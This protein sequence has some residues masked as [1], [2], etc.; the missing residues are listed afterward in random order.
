VID[1]DTDISTAIK[2]KNGEL[3]VKRTQDVEPY[4]DANKRM[5]ADQVGGW[6][7]THGKTRRQVAEIPNIV[8]E[9]W[10]KQGF[11]IFQVSERELRKKLDEPEW[12]Y[13]KTIPG[14]VGQRSRHI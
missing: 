4:L 13:L 7:R 9:M 5:Q 6:R 12:A 10:L 2:A 11:N 3:F 8:V 1:T 14:R